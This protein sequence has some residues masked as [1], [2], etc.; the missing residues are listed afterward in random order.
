MK[1]NDKHKFANNSQVTK[2][3]ISKCGTVK[4]NAIN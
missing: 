2:L 4:R 1:K 3:K